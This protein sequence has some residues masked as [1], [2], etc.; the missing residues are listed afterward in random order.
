MTADETPREA[1]TSLS[2]QE[3]TERCRRDGERIDNWSTVWTVLAIALWI[4][5]IVLLLTSYG[6]EIDSYSGARDNMC[7]GPLFASPRP[8]EECLSYQW[9]QWPALLGV[10]AL[11]VLLT[12]TAAATAVYAKIL[13]RMA[14]AGGHSASGTG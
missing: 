2:A 11:A 9:H 1:V 10:S 6:P 8:S 3:H 13:T 12:I 7:K 14:S 5:F 4:T